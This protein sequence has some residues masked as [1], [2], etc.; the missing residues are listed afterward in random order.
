VKGLAWSVQE[1]RSSQRRAVALI[2][3]G[4]LL[5]E[6]SRTPWD[7]LTPQYA[8][9]LKLSAEAQAVL[10]Q[11]KLEVLLDDSQQEIPSRQITVRIEWP[12]RQGA[13]EGSVVLNAWTFE[14]SR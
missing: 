14:E 10:P 3:A 11:A 4:N 5:D 13:H 2:E 9:E 12:G 8:S 7:T 1:R 6:L